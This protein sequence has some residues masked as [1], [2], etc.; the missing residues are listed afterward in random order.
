[1][2]RHGRAATFTC[3]ETD[4]PA[5]IECA[6]ER[7]AGNLSERCDTSG[8]EQRCAD[9]LNRNNVAA[10]FA[11]PAGNQQ[12]FLVTLFASRRHRLRDIVRRRY[13]APVILSAR[14]QFGCHRSRYSET[15][16]LGLQ[17]DTGLRVRRPVAPNSGLR[18]IVCKAAPVNFYS[19]LCKC[20]VVRIFVSASVRARPMSF[21]VR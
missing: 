14:G 7:L 2:D 6:A 20:N 21:P 10:E 12:P 3:L 1:M 18:W 16:A 15:C 4:N 5:A 13:A 17:A 9:L 19:S 11:F 8:D